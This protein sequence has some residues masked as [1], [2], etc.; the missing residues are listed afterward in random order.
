MLAEFCRVLVTFRASTLDPNGPQRLFNV[1]MPF[2]LYAVSADR[3]GNAGIH[4]PTHQTLHFGSRSRTLL[5]P[6]DHSCGAA[7]GVGRCRR[8]EGLQSRACAGNP[9]VF[10]IV[11]MVCGY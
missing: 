9:V 8:R 3:L 7:S 6:L 2:L 11:V 10:V 1:V 5:L 4:G